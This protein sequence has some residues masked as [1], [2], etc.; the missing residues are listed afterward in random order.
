MCGI[1]GIVQSDTTTIESIMIQARDAVDH[2][3]PDAANHQVWR[4]HGVAMAQRRLSIIDLSTAGTNPM[5]NEDETIWITYNGEVYNYQALRRE[6]EKA[7]HVFRSNTDTEVVIHA[8]EEW[9]DA[10]VDRLRG[11]F[12]YTIY[13][14]RSQPDGTPF[15][16]LLVRDRVGVKP[17]YYYWH[18]HIFIFAS[19]ITSIL[20]HPQ[21]N[22]TQD[23]TAI[24]DFLTYAYVPT[25]KTVYKHIRVLPPGHTLAF[26]GARINIQQYWDVPV[27]Q[28]PTIDT[29]AE[30]IEHVGSVLRDAVELHLVSDVPVGLF[31]SGGL[32]SSTILALMRSM[33]D[34][35]PHS[36]S[37]DFDVEQHSEIHYARI[38][39]EK[40][41]TNHHER[42]VTR[43]SIHDLLPHVLHMY[44]QP[45]ADNSSIPTWAVS[46]LAAEYVKVVLSGDGGDEVFFGYS[47]YER[48]LRL[49]QLRVIPEAI[50]KHG[51]RNL[52]SL[53]PPQA[54]G[55]KYKRYLEDIGD[56]ALH[57]YARQLEVLSPT[58]KRRLFAAHLADFEDYDDYWYFRK[59]W[60][61]DLHPIRRMQYLDLKTFLP[62]DILTKV[63]RATMQASLEARPPLL[64]YQLIEAVMHVEPSILFKN[65]EKKYLLKQ[66]I[67]DSLPETILN[68]PKKGFSTPMVQWIKRDPAVIDQQ[69]SYSNYFQHNNITSK[70]SNF[71]WG[72][73]R[74]ALLLLEAWAAGEAEYI[75]V[76]L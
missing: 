24:F 65:G 37:I 28:I 52:G 39:A 60:R 50:R 19:E 4:D 75:D 44:G 27:D 66:I 73:K 69:L 32:D 70:L 3:G 22:R 59:F 29:E 16:M 68:R 61:D 74:W 40:F 11:M 20:Q 13:D 71:N 12:A 31:L 8:Y 45:F 43:H 62:D 7:G 51:I 55:N 23:V 42:V 21:V 57:Q 76:Q 48:W 67:R 53:W 17:L 5:P 49:Q 15:R 63:D 64:D 1:C 25:P 38:A 2:R 56:N 47:W 41:N 10:H 34:T 6:L 9:G 18:N 54:R 46:Q 36:F 30:A 35:P 58:E 26:D 33:V 14:R 72:T